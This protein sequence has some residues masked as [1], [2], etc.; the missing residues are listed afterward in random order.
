ME[1]TGKVKWFDTVK[2]Y[3]FIEP[4]DGS[5]DIF[6]HYKELKDENHKFIDPDEGE[7]LTVEVQPRP[8]GPRAI[9]IKEGGEQSF[10]TNEVGYTVKRGDFDGSRKIRQ[11]KQ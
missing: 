10:N 8:S 7:E 1:V 5:P 2:G 3:G 6:M 11:F 9:K 4:E